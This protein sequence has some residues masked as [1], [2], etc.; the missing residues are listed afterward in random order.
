MGYKVDNAVI[1][2]AGFSNRFAQISYEKQ[3]ALLEVR[4]EIMIELEIRQ[5]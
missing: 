3:K 1:M 2:A 5:L 4:G